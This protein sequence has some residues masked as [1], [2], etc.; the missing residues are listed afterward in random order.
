MMSTQTQPVISTTADASDQPAAGGSGLVPYRLT[1]RQFETMTDAGVFHDDDHVELLGGLLVDEMVKKDPHHFATDMLGAILHD[2]LPTERIARQ[3]K[4]IVL[5]RFWRPEP[6][7]AIVR[8]PRERFR[9]KGPRR[10]DVAML[11]EVADSTCA[12]DRGVK[13]RQYAASRVPV[14]WIV[15]LALRQIEVYSAPA[16]RGKSAAYGVAIICRA[17]EE[18]LVILEGREFGRIKVSE[19]LA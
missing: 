12:K 11:V 1:V 13:W 19:I 15:N 14:Y 4:S 2:G 7:I 17:D 16:G 8:G 3:D 6:D 18:V 9:S 5:G 10:A